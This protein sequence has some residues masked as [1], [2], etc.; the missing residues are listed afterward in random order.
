MSGGLLTTPL[1]PVNFNQSALTGTFWGTGG[2]APSSSGIDLAGTGGSAF[3]QAWSTTYNVVLV[4][5]ASG[6]TILWYYCGAT[7]AGIAQVLVGE[8]W[9]GQVLP[10]GTAQTIAANSSGWFGAYSPATYNIKNTALVQSNIAGAP[11][12]ASWPNAALGCFA[13]AFTTV[14]SLY[15]RAYT[16]AGIQP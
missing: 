5:N 4:P 6:N 13:V 1:T 3:A 8:N 16:F 15:V 10:A 11:T 7:P 12:I 9:A 14:T 2:S